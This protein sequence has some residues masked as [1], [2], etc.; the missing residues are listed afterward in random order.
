MLPSLTLARRPRPQWP[1]RL[2]AVILILI[3]AFA[4]CTFQAQ[5]T[6]PQEISSRDVEPTFK[7]Q[8]ERNLVMVRVVVRNAQ[9]ATVDNLRKEDFQLFDHGK[10]QTILHF[11]LE[12]PALKGPAPAAPK[13][14]E[15]AAEP[16]VEEETAR[17]ASAAQRFVALYFD[18]VNTTF[19]GIV[20]AR[21]AADHFLTASI[22]PGD[23]VALF[24]SSG[25][26]QVD[27]TSDLAQIHQALLELH[28]R[29]IAGQDASSCV[30]IPPYEAYLIVDHNDPL[31]L[32]VASLKVLS[33]E[34]CPLDDPQSAQACVTTTQ[35]EAVSEANRLYS[36]AEAEART[37]LQG[38][39]SVVRRMAALPGQRSVIIVSTGFFTETLRY[40]LGQIADHALR[41]NVILNALDARGL[42]TDPQMADVSQ[43]QLVTWFRQHPGQLLSMPLQT[44]PRAMAVENARRQT[45]GMQALALDTGGLFFNNS[46]DL[47]EGF[48]KLAGA[49]EAFYVLAFSPQNLKTD[50]AFHPLQVKLVS[51]KGMT[52]QARKGYYAPK[53]PN[54]PVEQAKEELHEA[55]LSQEETHELP[56]DVHTKFFMKTETDARVTVLTRIDLRAL[57]LRKETDRNVDNLTFVTAMFDRDGRVIS[58]L[59]KSVDLHLRDASLE[60]LLQTGISIQSD[61]DVKPGTYLVRAVVRDSESGQISGLNR[62]VEIP[63]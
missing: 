41:A 44:A 16:E 28:Q 3:P 6:N 55:V 9:G 30:D 17:P 25:Q 10:L 19:E 15:K 35:D 11:S 24:T 59:Q 39:E 29:P 53:K 20:R 40:D 49:P 62:T 46:N 8:A 26:K 60:R 54:D 57:H 63:Y 22:Q 50:G 38:I 37:A 61:F 27:F 12:K 18:D 2:L 36:L 51:A 4:P 52:V 45:D 1:S 21:E 56:I 34:T 47:R 48:R 58:V 31:A 5:T 13:P 43:T 23:R 33:C 14:A 32:A 7:L 42:Y